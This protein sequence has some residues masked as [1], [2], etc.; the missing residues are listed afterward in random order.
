M[1][2]SYSVERL[3]TVLY[4][5]RPIYRPGQTVNWKGIVRAIAEDDTY[6]LP[7]AG[8]TVGVVIRDDM[9]NTILQRSYTVNE[10]GTINGEL[11]LAE[12]AGT[13][14]YYLESRIEISKDRSLYAGTSFQVAEYR[15]PEFEIS[16]ESVDPEYIQGDTVRVRVQASYFSGGPLANA[17]VDW[18]LLADAYNFSWADAPRGATSASSPP[19]WTI[20]ASTRTPTPSSACSKRGPA[21]PT[22]TASSS[23]NCLPTWAKRSSASA[24]RWT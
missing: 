4:T 22:R 23:S 5:D 20:K 16:V 13:G 6:E 24:G 18:R 15:A 8:L 12:T 19:R 11:T 2:T 1:Q 9:G 3:R 21:S 10:N 7:P 14:Y 17:P